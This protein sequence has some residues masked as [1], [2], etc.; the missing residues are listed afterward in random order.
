MV[1]KDIGALL[2]H[3]TGTLNPIINRMI[4]QGR[5]T[6]RQSPDDRRSWFISLTEQ[7]EKEQKPISQAVYDKLIGCNLLNVN[8]QSLMKNVKQLNAFF[9]NLDL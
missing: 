8:A 6:K 3:G 9:A 4:E 5:L 7:A 2:G 1:T